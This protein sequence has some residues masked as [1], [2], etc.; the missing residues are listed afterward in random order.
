MSLHSANLRH[1]L[2]SHVCR[3]SKCVMTNT[4][5]NCNCGDITSLLEVGDARLGDVF[6][7]HLP[8]PRPESYLIFVHYLHP[9]ISAHARLSHQHHPN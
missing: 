8:G 6:D 9:G 1:P 4:F 5:I 3:R 7:R 2:N